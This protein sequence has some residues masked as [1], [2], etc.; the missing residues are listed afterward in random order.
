[1]LARQSQAI[2]HRR[3]VATVLAPLHQVDA[4][5]IGSKVADERSSRVAAA[6]VDDDHLLETARDESGDAPQHGLDV[7]RGVVRGDHHAQFHSELASR[8]S[9]T[10]LAAAT[11][12]P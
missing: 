10:A 3:A 8:V 9:R 12:S 4:K 1:A 2:F 7:P 5:G 11:R 6:I